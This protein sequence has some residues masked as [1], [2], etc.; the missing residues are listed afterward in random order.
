[1]VGKEESTA[2]LLDCHFSVTDDTEML[3]CMAYLLTEECYLNLLDD[4]AVDNPLDMEAIKEQQDAD[5]DLI[6][7]ATKYTDRYIHKSVSAIDNA[8]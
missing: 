8:L 3:K 6:R 5:N 7:Q 2:D 4:S 1:M